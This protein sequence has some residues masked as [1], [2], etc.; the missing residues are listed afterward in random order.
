VAEN[1][2]LESRIADF[3]AGGGHITGIC[4]GYQ[5]MG[6]RVHDPDGLE[7]EPGATA[8]LGLLPVETV[9]QAPK[10][11]TL[12]RFSWDGIQGTGYE[13]HMGRTR[14]H[15]G[16]PLLTIHERNGDSRK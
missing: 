1:Q 15:G 12:S 14:S 4:G 16:K 3:S 11:T 10:T 8:G 5:M 13:I 7:G 6:T 9:L 2:R